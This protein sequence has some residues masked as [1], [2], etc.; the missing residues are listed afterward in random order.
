VLKSVPVVPSNTEIVREKSY[1]QIV[2]QI[3]LGKEF[4]QN[5]VE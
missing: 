2:S 3:M 5:L 1:Y 4:P